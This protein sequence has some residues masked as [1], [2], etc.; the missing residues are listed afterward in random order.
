MSAYQGGKG[1]IGRRIHDV[2]VLVEKDIEKGYRSSYFEPFIGMAG[3]MKHFAKDSIEDKR[4]LYA[5]DVNKDLILL[6]R[7][8]QNGWEPPLE[9]TKKEYERL[10]TAKPSAKRAF[11]GIAASY[12]TVFFN[13]YR[14]DYNRN[15][16]LREAY[17][18]L[19]KVADIMQRVYFM[20]ADS[21]DTWEPE[22]YLIYCDPPYDKNGLHSKYFQNFDHYKFWELMR[23]WSKKNIVIISESKSPKDFKKIW[24]TQSNCKTQHNNKVY[25]D[26]L[27][28]HHDVWKQLSTRVKR[29]IKNI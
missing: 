9:C 5:C 11:I 25:K 23:K 20:E 27:F 26:C 12:G 14:L 24:C 10:K 4:Q 29:E 22:G 19:M 15:N 18:G 17:N 2:I 28:I 1:R 3:V 7:A 13:G 21:Y 16:Y 8:I 6:W